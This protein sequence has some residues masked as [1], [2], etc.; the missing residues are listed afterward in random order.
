L[1]D[2]RP[3]RKE[4]AVLVILDDPTNVWCLSYRRSL[5]RGVATPPARQR[6]SHRRAVE[7][8]SSHS[9]GHYTSLALARRLCLLTTNVHVAMAQ[10]PR[11]TLM[12]KTHWPLDARTQFPRGSRRPSPDVALQK[13]SNYAATPLAAKAIA[14]PAYATSWRPLNKEPPPRRKFDRSIDWV[15]K[16]I[17]VAPHVTSKMPL[18]SVRQD[19][20]ECPA[21]QARQRVSLE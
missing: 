1:L 16:S 17:M 2:P 15:T 19:A 11:R 7:E 12:V 8:V 9:T 14:A 10:A 4:P 6:H 5:S 3:Q 18:A 20:D 21:K 13:R